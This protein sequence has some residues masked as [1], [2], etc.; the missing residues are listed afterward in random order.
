MYEALSRLWDSVRA[1]AV[2]VTRALEGSGT[3]APLVQ[4][5]MATHITPSAVRYYGVREVRKPSRSDSRPHHAAF[6]GSR[7]SRTLPEM[8]QQS[9]WETMIEA[10]RNAKGYRWCGLCG[11]YHPQ[12]TSCDTCWKQTSK[13]ATEDFA[14]RQIG[15]ECTY[16]GVRHSA[17]LDCGE[18]ACRVRNVKTLILHIDQTR[19]SFWDSA[20]EAEKR[21][22]AWDRLMRS[23]EQK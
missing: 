6:A 4:R 5:G 13:D 22:Q 1:L 14:I 2:F 16:C 12:S 15:V 7:G 18:Y 17:T 19:R 9:G 3:Q 8:Q 10:M 21:W 11:Y 20:V 23:L